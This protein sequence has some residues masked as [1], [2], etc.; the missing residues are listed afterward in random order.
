MAS[1]KAIRGLTAT[2]PIARLL[3]QKVGKSLD[4]QVVK[5]AG[6]EQRIRILEAEVDRLRPRKR[7]KVRLDPNERFGGIEQIMKAKKELGKRLKASD[8]VNSYVFEEMCLEWSIFDPVV[9]S[10]KEVEN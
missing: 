8:V 7:M 9:D 2:D 10:E 4:Y 5:L 6:Q 3:F 1:N